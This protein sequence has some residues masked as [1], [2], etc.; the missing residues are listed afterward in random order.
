[1]DL[2]LLVNKI[3]SLFENEEVKLLV[4]DDVWLDKNHGSGIHSTGFCFSSCEVIY[5]LTGGKNRWFIKSIDKSVWD[6]GTHY[7]LQDK[8]TSEILDITSNQYTDRGIEI[9]YTL[10]RAKGLRNTSK[11]AKKLAT[12]LKLEL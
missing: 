6:E 10:G 3:K 11:K 4:L 8:L 2:E 5:R 9:P 12:F 1:M 7:F